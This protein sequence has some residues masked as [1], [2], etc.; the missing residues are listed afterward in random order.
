M[1]GKEYV[2]KVIYEVEKRNGG[3]VEFLNAV[4]EVL[5]SLIP[6]FDKHPEYI[7]EGIL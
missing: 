5:Y 3:E 7:E 4:K 1:S 6:V 2:N